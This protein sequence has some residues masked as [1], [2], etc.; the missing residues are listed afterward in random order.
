MLVIASGLPE[1]GQ[2]PRRSLGQLVH[3]PPKAGV[4]AARLSSLVTW[5]LYPQYRMFNFQGAREGNREMRPSL[6]AAR[7]GFLQG[8]FEKFFELFFCP[9]Q[10]FGYALLLYAFNRRNLVLSQSIHIV[11][12]KASV[13]SLGQSAVQLFHEQTA[14][15][16]TI[17]LLL[18]FNQYIFRR[19][20]GNALIILI[21]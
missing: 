11:Q 2:R 13:L 1:P 4:L 12:P 7:M 5:V 9:P 14:E 21:L 3:S 15:F 6:N 10:T 20:D 18:G 16:L 8:G 19:L 17:L